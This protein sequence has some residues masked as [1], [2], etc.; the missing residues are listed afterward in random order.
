MKGKTLAIGAA[1]AVGALYL[2]GRRTVAGTAVVPN[3]TGPG[4]HAADPDISPWA[5]VLTGW[6]RVRHAFETWSV[7]A[8]TSVRGP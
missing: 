2:L 1:V 6:A 5:A 7:G 8:V 3:A 4:F